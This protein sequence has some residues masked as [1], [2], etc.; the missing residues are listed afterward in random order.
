MANS[1]HWL[2]THQPFAP[3]HLTNTLVGGNLTGIDQGAGCVGTVNDGPGGQPAVSEWRF[4]RNGASTFVDHIRMYPNTA[5]EQRPYDGYYNIT[6]ELV[7]LGLLRARMYVGPNPGNPFEVDINYFSDISVP[8]QACFT[9]SCATGATPPT[10]LTDFVAT[11]GVQYAGVEVF[12]ASGDYDQ[13]D[14]VILCSTPTYTDDLT[15]NAHASYSSQLSFLPSNPG[16]G[17]GPG[18]P[19]G[20]PCTNISTQGGNPSAG[21]PGG[22]IGSGG[23][24]GTPCLNPT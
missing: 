24:T 14:F 10:L 15:L 3:A 13:F 11:C 8:A 19:V 20:T 22:A 6:V 23:P 4:S 16:G 5:S 9:A 18:G 7:A 17:L 12:W 1:S 2:I 21:N